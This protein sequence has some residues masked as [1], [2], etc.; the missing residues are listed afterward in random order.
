MRLPV[1]VAVSVTVLG[2]RPDSSTEFSGVPDDQAMINQL[3]VPSNCTPQGL[4]DFCKYWQEDDVITFY[5]GPGATS[6]MMQ[7]VGAAASSW[8]AVGV[9]QFAVSTGTT[10]DI[11]VRRGSDQTGTGWCGETDQGSDSAPPAYLN[12]RT[13]NCG[14]LASV[15]LHELS[16]VAGYQGNWHKANEF[17]LA[18][19]EHAGHCSFFLRANGGVNQA[20]ATSLCQHEIEGVKYV[21]GGRESSIPSF[22]A[23]I[24]TGVRAPTMP[25]TI[26]FGGIVMVGPALLRYSHSNGSRCGLTDWQSC[27]EDEVGT[28]GAT[29]TL[30]NQNLWTSDAPTIATV[31]GSSTGATITGGS[32]TGQA[33]IH[34]TRNLS[35]TRSASFQSASRTIIVAN[36]PTPPAGAPSNVTV[37]G[38]GATSATVSWS[39]GDASSGVTTFIDYRTAAA[40]AWTGATGTFGLPAEQSSFQ[41]TGLSASTTYY[42]RMYHRRDGI[43]SAFA[44]ASGPFTTL[45]PPPPPPP[46]PP[47]SN[48]WVGGC[49]Q[50]YY[51]SKRYNTWTISWSPVPSSPTVYYELLEGGTNNTGSGSIVASGKANS[52]AGEVG[53]YLDTTSANY[54]YFW[55]RFTQSGVSTAW[56]PLDVNPLD[57]AGSCAA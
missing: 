2:C 53:P 50:S 56:V 1:L 22:T 46:L 16:H 30:N 43:S 49:E 34:I 57:V 45:A 17:G 52:G 39:N 31:Q 27:Q 9:L 47:P 51:G 48:V 13:G 28:P 36:I 15:A 32:T 33:R 18:S 7:A 12:L 29:A 14:T 55:V 54:R 26:D 25:D 42:V 19:I 40:T 5:P 11:Q 4:P 38:I 6:A 20:R 24:I 37:S 35:S 21:Y 23:H 41:L 44:A 10:G 8:N 3:V